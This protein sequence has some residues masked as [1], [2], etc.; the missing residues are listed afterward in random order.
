MLKRNYKQ[1]LD[2]QLA[3]LRKQQKE[4]QLS[5]AQDSIYQLLEQK[6]LLRYELGEVS[7]MD[8]ILVHSKSARSAAQIKQLQQALTL[9]WAQLHTLMAYAGPAFELSPAQ[10]IELQKLP[11]VSDIQAHP[12]LEQYELN[13]QKIK[14]D[15]QLVKA[16]QVPQVALGYFNQ[17]LVGT[18]NISGQDVYFGPNQRFQGAIVQSQIPID[19]KAFQKRKEAL[20]IELKQN[21]LL[22]QQHLQQ[23]QLEQKQLYNKLLEMSAAYTDFSS[24]IKSE[25]ALLQ[26]DAALQ[27]ES[28]QISLLDYM[29]LQDHKMALELE[30]IQWQYELK[31][32][33]IQYNWYSNENN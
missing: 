31:T 23:L 6:M 13:A 28:G 11:L 24:T 9:S 33:H 15:M 30:L 21:G 17:T 5:K 1:Q 20:A 16:Q 7:K 12:A 14:F 32:I 25:L 8:Y 18:Q 4:L 27:L 3:F 26:T 22:Q 19:F 2:L 29:Q 10:E